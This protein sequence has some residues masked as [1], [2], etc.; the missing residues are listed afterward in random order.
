MTIDYD[1]EL[2][3]KLLI[4]GRKLEKTTAHKLEDSFIETILN[5][6][7]YY[8]ASKAQLSLAGFDLF[9][10]KYKIFDWLGMAYSGRIQD[11]NDSIATKSAH[12]CIEKMVKIYIYQ[13]HVGGFAWWLRGHDLDVEDP[14]RCEDCIKSYE[15]WHN[16]TPQQRQQEQE[17]R[18]KFYGGNIF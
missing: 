15:Y 2:H 17:D 1:Q 18:E 9:N 13:S 11:Q 10:A 4:V 5:T 3:S 7:E 14:M 6:L 12:N 8:G 16:Q